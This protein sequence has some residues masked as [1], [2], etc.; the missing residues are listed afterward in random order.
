M[1]DLDSSGLH[2]PLVP[3][4]GDEDSADNLTTEE[5]PSEELWGRNHP[6]AD[7][8]RKDSAADD[9]E[10]LAP[11]WQRKMV[12]VLVGVGVFC[13][14]AMRSNIS[15]AMVDMPDRYGWPSYWT[16]PVLSAFFGGYI[17]GQVPAS[18][19]AL[20]H[21]ARRIL[22]LAL[23][24][25]AFFNFLIPIAAGSPLSVCVLRVLIG[26]AQ[27]G[28]FPCTYQLLAAWTTI[29][30]KSRGIA[31]IRSLGESGGAMTGLLLS[32]V[33]LEATVRMWGS[34]YVPGLYSV[35]WVWT[36]AALAWAIVWLALV[37]E[38][39]PPKYKPSLE[40][41]LEATDVVPATETPPWGMFVRR[42]EAL[43]LYCNHVASSC[44]QYTMLTE[45]PLFLEQSLG[46]DDDG[47]TRLALILP[48]SA[49]IVTMAF[50]SWIVDEHLLKS[51]WNRD[52]VRHGAQALGLIGCGVSLLGCVL[53]G[54]ALGEHGGVAIPLAL[55]TVGYG[56]FALTASG[57]SP[58][59]LECC[60]RF[61]GQLYSIS[62][63]ASTMAG[64]LCPLIVELLIALLGKAAGW[65]A[66]FG[67][68]GLGV[69]IPAVF[70][71]QKYATTEPLRAFNQSVEERERAPSE[72]SAS[73]NE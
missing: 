60:P 13:Q 15:V 63:A 54:D 71:F 65:Q 25:T 4:G 52:K 59:Y 5:I 66:A 73:L 43:A 3:R 36:V 39:K 58:V 62:N 42:P 12:T 2:K 9:E 6:F 33:L 27:S 72:L 35:F 67:L 21:G 32:E 23:V 24:G 22:A 41:R 28:T 37:P 49:N 1:E 17:F 51:G 16:G 46:M 61:S 31:V 50:S 10:G 47:T 11:A 26:L 53:V 7:S 20:K 29:E 30:E 69:G 68:F 34:A 38:R 45:L 70:Y 55:L 19:I 14:Y 8:I 64:I 57:F 40:T 18:R 48:Y 56:V 44:V